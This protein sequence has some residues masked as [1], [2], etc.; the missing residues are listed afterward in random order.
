MNK[1]EKIPS[2]IEEGR[3]YKICPNCNRKFYLDELI[4]YYK[5]SWSRKKYCSE[6]CRDF[7]GESKQCEHCG[8]IYYT[9]LMDKK[10]RE[11]SKYC[12]KICMNEWHNINALAKLM[13]TDYSRLKE[14]LL[15]FDG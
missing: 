14:Y 9:K 7:S 12:S 15:K 6:R 10:Q 1:F 5:N 4:G 3:E 2:F 8:E 11:K 13:G